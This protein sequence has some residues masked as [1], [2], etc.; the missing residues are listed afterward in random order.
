LSDICRNSFNV[1]EKSEGNGRG[2][3]KGRT[4]KR[5]KNGIS[6]KGR[7]KIKV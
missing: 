7:K 5:C 4:N 2:I 6:E 1:E 3:G